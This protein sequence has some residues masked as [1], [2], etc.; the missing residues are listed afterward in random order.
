MP[1]VPDVGHGQPNALGKLLVYRQIELQG[2]R[3]LGIVVGVL[4]RAANARAGHRDRAAARRNA[5]QGKEIGPFAGVQ[6]AVVL[7][8]QGSV[9][10]GFWVSKA[11][12]LATS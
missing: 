3:R 12:R 1:R 10:V 8:T 6:L 7:A 5:A 11:P 9:P 4:Q 2:V